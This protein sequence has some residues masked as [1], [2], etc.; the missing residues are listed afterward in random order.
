MKCVV[1]KEM[2]A[3]EDRTSYSVLTEK[4]IHSILNASK[5]RQDT[6]EVVVG[7][8]VHVLR[9]SRYINKKLMQQERKRFVSDTTGHINKK[10]KL[11]SSDSFD[12]ISQCLYWTNTVTQREG[13]DKKAYQ[14][15]SKRREFD[16]TVLQIC[17][18][19]N[20]SLALSVKGRIAKTNDLRMQLML[21]IT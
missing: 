12:Y 14:V 10:A 9:R 15:V 20:D 21:S 5:E 18:T 16:K 3:G 4:G 8:V 19:R 13:R 17:E 1:C 2:V 7:E 11:R 6:L